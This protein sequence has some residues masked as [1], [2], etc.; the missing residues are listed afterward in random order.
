MDVQIHHLKD[1]Q[2][3]IHAKNITV[4]KEKTT[5]IIAQKT[6]STS[7]DVYEHVEPEKKGTYEKPVVKPDMKT[8]RQ[9]Q[10]ESNRAFDHLKQIVREMLKRQGLKFRDIDVSQTEQPQ[11]EEITDED[12]KDVKID[13]I[14]QKEAQAMIAEGGE[15]SA[16]SVSDRIVNFAKAISGG[17]KSKLDLLKSAI[18][19]GFEAAEADFGDELP[20]ISKETYKLIMSKLD[21]WAKEDETPVDGP[22]NQGNSQPAST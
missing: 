14:A 6:I 16:E 18:D 17:D 19:Q 20:E 9:L 2:N 21:D 12:L 7:T 5:E 4:K 11:T 22:E 8:I 15:Y 10:E 1:S 13:E 3:Q